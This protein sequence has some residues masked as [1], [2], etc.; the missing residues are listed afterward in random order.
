[1]A[2]KKKT[3]KSKSTK[4]KSSKYNSKGTNVYGAA[5]QPSRTQRKVAQNISKTIKRNDKE[6][7]SSKKAASEAVSTL[8]KQTTAAPAP[9]KD[10]TMMATNY[11]ISNP[12]GFITDD[13]RIQNTMDAATKSAY[14]VKAQ[15]AAQGLNAAEDQSYANTQNAVKGLKDSMLSSTASGANRGA[16]GANAVQALLGLGQ[17]NNA[18]T[19]QGLQNIQN[20]AGER[21]AAMAQNAAD[22]INISNTARQSQGDLASQK[23]QADTGLAGQKYSADSE[24]ELGRYQ[25][26]QNYRSAAATAMGSL[27]GSMHTDAYNKEM[28]DSTN[29]ANTA[30]AYISGKRDNITARTTGKYNVKAAKVTGKYNV[31]AARAG[32]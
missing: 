2:N 25:A 31:K 32:R 8:Q 12:F 22:A 10:P 28:N 19:T 7:Q 21:A 30:I 26:D 27:A 9:V 23:Y 11:D 1:M 3:T 16:A 13:K 4:S 17:Q 18:L 14:D 15:E 5:S 20:V 24:R 29:N 6:A